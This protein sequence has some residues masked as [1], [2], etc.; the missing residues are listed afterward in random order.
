M[1][2]TGSYGVPDRVDLFLV[3]TV[4]PLYLG[5]HTLYLCARN[6]TGRKLLEIKPI[7]NTVLLAL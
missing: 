3:E 2:S 4:V 7:R 5:L 1:D 6:D